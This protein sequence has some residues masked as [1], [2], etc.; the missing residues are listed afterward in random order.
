MRKNDKLYQQQYKS[1]QNQLK[2]PD[3]LRQATHQKMHQYQSAH[4]EPV[5]EPTPT[6]PKRN[7]LSLI[8]LTVTLLIASGLYYLS[9]TASNSTPPSDNDE[10]PYQPEP[11]QSNPQQIASDPTTEDYPPT[12]EQTTSP[13]E[14]SIRHP[15]PRPP[16]ENRN[17]GENASS[18]EDE[19]RF[20]III[21]P[22]HQ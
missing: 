15:Q 17:N 7:G 20:Q 2:T 8:F 11:S 18:N 3:D 1:E 4:P 19:G 21:R 22:P 12:E 16:E 14:S 6:P 5:I 13:T 9:V 10:M